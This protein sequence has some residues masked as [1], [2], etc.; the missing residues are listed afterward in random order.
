MI[1]TTE[2]SFKQAEG[3]TSLIYDEQSGAN[4]HCQVGAM[5]LWTADFFEWVYDNL[6]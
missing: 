2:A 3:I 5:N 1:A 4:E 6:S